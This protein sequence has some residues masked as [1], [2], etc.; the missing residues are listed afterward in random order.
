MADEM[1]DLELDDEELDD[2]ELEEDVEE[3]DED[4]EEG[5]APVDLKALMARLDRQESLNKELTQA[6]SRFQGLQARNE[7]AARP[8]P[9]VVAAQEEAMDEVYTLLHALTEG[10]DEALLVD[11]TVKSRARAALDARNSKK[12]DRAVEERVRAM[13]KDAVGDRAPASEGNQ[14][15]PEQLA[16]AVDA[17]EAALVEEIESYGLDPDDFDWKE[18]QAVLGKTGPNGLRKHIRTQIRAALKDDG[19]AS[20]RQSRKASV[21]KRPKG[22]AAGVSG[23]AI[24]S[25]TDLKAQREYLRSLGVAGV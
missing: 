22:G 19:A 12:A 3:E 9:K 8:D 7:A 1:D 2:E 13:V 21:G 25:G 6:V 18:A 20:R 24:L 5:D 14:P 10:V 4:D 17:L 23:E 11:P 15:S 16:A